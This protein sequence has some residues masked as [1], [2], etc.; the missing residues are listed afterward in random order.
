MDLLGAGFLIAAITCLLLV[1]ILHRALETFLI[2]LK[3]L[4]W[5][6]TTYAWKNSKVWGTLLG[7]GL[8]TIVFVLLQFRRG[9]RA[10]IPPR[11]LKQRTV[12]YSSIYSCFLS[13]GLYVS[14]FLCLAQTQANLN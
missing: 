11:I 13:M 8:L 3:A 14:N 5:G 7:F 10:T 1:R 6:G 4:Q 12:L 2:L 9:D